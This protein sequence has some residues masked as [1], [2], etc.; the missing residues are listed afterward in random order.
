MRSISDIRQNGLFFIACSES[1]KRE[2][3]GRDR[4][5]GRLLLPKEGAPD[6]P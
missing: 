3:G 4:R 6:P 1:R 2:G 5:H